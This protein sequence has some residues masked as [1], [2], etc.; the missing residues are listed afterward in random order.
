MTREPARSVVLALAAASLARCV[1]AT[2][3]LATF[4][5]TVD[6]V[7]PAPSRASASPPRNAWLES[8]PSGVLVRW[9]TQALTPG[10]VAAL[11]AHECEAFGLA[12]DPLGPPSRSG[13][14]TA[15]RF[16]C[17]PV[18]HRAATTGRLEPAAPIEGAGRRAWAGI[19]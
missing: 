17:V 19:S 2:P 14:A 9:G 10:Q 16:A 12:A 18:V 15:E 7:G 4:P 13:D 6:Y 5:V 1:P 8:V 11:A 3:S